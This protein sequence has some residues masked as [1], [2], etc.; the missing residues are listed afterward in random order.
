MNISKAAQSIEHALQ[1]MIHVF[2]SGKAQAAI[3]KAGA[4]VQFAMPIVQE[5]DTLVGGNKTLETVEAAYNHYGVPFVQATASNNLNTAVFQ[6]ATSVLQQK[7]PSDKAAVATNIL[8][9]AIQ[10]AVTGL[11]AE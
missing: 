2:T 4:Y 11:H 9:T 3:V 10:L 5:I 8:Q 6:L 1:S 7:L